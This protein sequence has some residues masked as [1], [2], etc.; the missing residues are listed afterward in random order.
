MT[1]LECCALGVPIVA[2]RTGGLVHL[3]TA[4]FPSGLVAEHNADAYAERLLDVLQQKTRPL[5]SMQ[6]SA[7]NN[8]VSMLKLYKQLLNK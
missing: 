5:F 3:L 8:A 1:A 6:Y 4:N 2:H 7:K